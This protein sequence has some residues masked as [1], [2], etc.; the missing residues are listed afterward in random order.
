MATKEVKASFFNKRNEESQSRKT[1]GNWA[2]SWKP[3]ASKAGT[4][5]ARNV[6]RFMPPHENMPD[7]GFVETK[8]HFLPEKGPDGAPVIGK[9]GQ[10][11]PIGIGCLAFY[12]EDCPACNHVDRL[13]RNAKAEETPEAID[14]AKKFAASLSAKLRFI[15]NI[16]DMD[17]PEKGVQRYAF[18]PDVEKAI[19]A[20]WYDDEGE[21]RNISHPNTGRDIIMLVTKK[22]GTDF[23]EYV[24]V[25]ARE[26][27]TKLADMAWLEQIT[28]LSVEARKPTVAEVEAAL[29]GTRLSKDE[30]K[31][32]APV[33]AAKPLKKAP[34][35]VEAEVEEEEEE[36]TPPPPK[37]KTAAPVVEEKPKSKR[38]PIPEPEPE[39]EEEEEET[40]ADPFAQARKVIAKAGVQAVEITPDEVEKIKKPTCYTKETEVSDPACQTCRVLLPC[41]TAKMMAEE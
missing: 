29:K 1:G 13:F 22:Q 18:G 3:T 38:Q 23:N 28:D 8:L 26:K 21:F 4:A 27:E 16:V 7:D 5:P 35:P 25:K 6:I 31:A 24:T 15:I 41:L 9:N 40:E 32:A 14:K 34:E 37:K 2:E 10:P 33:A 12:G 17:H 20:C 30:K 19:R 39:V 11:V 36:E